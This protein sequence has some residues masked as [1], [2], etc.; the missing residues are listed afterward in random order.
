[1]YR[2][3]TAIICK[4]DYYQNRFQPV[5]ILTVDKIKLKVQT[6]PNKLAITKKKKTVELSIHTVSF[7]LNKDHLELFHHYVTTT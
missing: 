5:L 1:M 2:P 3:N 6:E 7:L 4:R